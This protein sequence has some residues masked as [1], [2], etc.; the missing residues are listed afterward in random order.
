MAKINI[1]QWLYKHS[2]VNFYSITD[3]GET[4]IK[5]INN[6]FGGYKLNKV[7]EADEINHLRRIIKHFKRFSAIALLLFYIFVIY[8]FVFPYYQLFRKCSVKII[9]IVIVILFTW[10]ILSV[11]SKI[12]ECYLK[13]NYGD[14][15]KTHFP[16]SNFIEN[17]SYNDFKK[18]LVKIFILL[19]VVAGICIGIGSPSEKAYKLIG[20]EQ[21]DKVVK[22]TTIWAKVLP[23]DSQCYSLRAYAEFY[24]GDYKGAIRDYDRAYKLKTDEYKSMSFDNKIYIKYYLK[25]YKSAIKDFDNE[26]KN[27][28]NDDEKDSLLWDKAQFLYNVGY[29]KDALK[30]YNELI[31]KSS[32]DRIYLMENRLYFERAQLYKK[33]GKEKEAQED[34]NKAQDL[35]LDVEFQNPI[36][37]PTLLLDEM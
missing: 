27:T 33:L 29:Y 2:P 20:N 10:A 14:F 12:F 9:A 15:K 8:G 3:D 5:S 6:T 28:Q 1:L 17:Q 22:F 21:Y 34:L 24:T 18:E 19:V 7:L 31:K 30:L 11:I 23:I 25:E 36:P 13:K 4:I 16:S 26:I 32:Q 37:E 35:N